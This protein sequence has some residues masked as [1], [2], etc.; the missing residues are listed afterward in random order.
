[1][2]QNKYARSAWATAAL[3]VVSAALVTIPP[4]ANSQEPKTPTYAELVEKAKSGDP[5]VDFADSSSLAFFFH[6]S[7][8]LAEPLSEFGATV[9]VE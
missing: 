8:R 1:M 5:T 7:S 3:L 6:Y 2:T 4:R 9:I